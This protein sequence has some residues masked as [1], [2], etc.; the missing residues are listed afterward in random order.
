MA[1]VARIIMEYY[2]SAD[3]LS[4]VVTYENKVG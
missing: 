2:F 1:K 3:E 4:D